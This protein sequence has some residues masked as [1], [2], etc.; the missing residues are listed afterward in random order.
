MRFSAFFGASGLFD[1]VNGSPGKR[2][3]SKK[4]GSVLLR[5]QGVCVCACESVLV[6]VQEWDMVELILLQFRS[7][8]S[9]GIV[10]VCLV[11][12]GQPS[13]AMLQSVNCFCVDKRVVS[14]N[15]YCFFVFNRL[16]VWVQ[17][18]PV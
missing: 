13:G 16:L 4:E 8:C 10:P 15:T 3:N 17:A 9:S 7:V 12:F 14:C 5:M 6:F 1:L 18:V 11:V 2:R